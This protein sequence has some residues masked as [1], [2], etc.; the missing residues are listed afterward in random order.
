MDTKKLVA[1]VALTGTIVAGTAGLA[2][3]ADGSGSSSGDPSAQLKHPRL[4]H[5]ARAAGKVVLDTVGGTAQQLRA[6]LEGG[7]T[8]AGYAEAHGS[9]AQAVIDALVTAGGGRIDRAVANGRISPQKG[10]AIKAKLPDLATKLVD[11]TWGQ[12]AQV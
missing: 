1:G 12:H 7:G 6:F 9:S 11:R 8:V 5:A 2:F 4:R 10:D 3:A